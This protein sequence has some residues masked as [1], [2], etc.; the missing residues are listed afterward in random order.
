MF[1]ISC[2]ILNS[3]LI[4][5]AQLSYTNGYLPE[6]T[7]GTVLFSEDDLDRTCWDMESLTLLTSRMILEALIPHKSILIVQNNIIINDIEEYC[8]FVLDVVK[9]SI[10]GKTKR[11]VLLALTDI[12]GGYLQRFVI[13]IA[14]YSYYAGYISYNSMDKLYKLLEQM[15]WFLN[16]KGKGWSECEDFFELHIEALEVTQ[17]NDI[18]ACEHLMY[19]NNK[20]E[21]QIPLPFVDSMTNPTAIAVP[22]KN[23]SIIGIESKHSSYILVDYY[24]VALNCLTS[25][26]VNESVIKDFKSGLLLWIHIHIL[27]LLNKGKFYAAFGGV[28]RITQALKHEG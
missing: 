12:L 14:K 19:N 21:I 8:H 20:G 9:R 16:T 26:Q 22:L 18:D 23:R 27:P 7:V 24:T 1:I 25:S 6:M 10:E 15:K 3:L 17:Q 4:S 28:L 13:P 2:L 11:I 5:L